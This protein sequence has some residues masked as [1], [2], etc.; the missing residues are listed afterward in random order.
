MLRINGL[1]AS[2]TL[3]AEVTNLLYMADVNTPTGMPV[4]HSAGKEGKA[5]ATNAGAAVN[6]QVKVET[7][8]AILTIITVCL[9]LLSLLGTCIKFLA[10]YDSVY[11]TTP[12]FNLDTEA[13]IP[14]FFSAMLL[15]CAGGLFFTVALHKKAVRDAFTWQWVLLSLIFVYLAFD[16]ATEIHGLVMR[17]FNSLFHFSGIFHFSWIVLGLL[18]LAVAGVYFLKLYSSFSPVFKRRFLE[19]AFVF[20]SGLLGMEMVSG[21]Y[22]DSYGENNIT[23]ELLTTIEE[24]LE[25]AGIILLIRAL[26]LYI[27]QHVASITFSVRSNVPE[28]L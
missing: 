19:A 5:L 18:L 15:L 10:G 8:V 26:L 23:Y 25:M 1:T 16:E 22:A 4:E 12:K 27:K 2:G 9:A 6:L 17:P 24:I 13:N 20:I 28:K 7:I 3:R 11:G 21:A 14:T